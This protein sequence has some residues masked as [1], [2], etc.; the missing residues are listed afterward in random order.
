MFKCLNVFLFGSLKFE[1][2][3]IVNHLTILKY[4]MAGEQ[5]ATTMT[6]L[7]L[8]V[9]NEILSEYMQHMDVKTT[10]MFLAT[11]KKTHNLDIE[12]S[13][14]PSVA[15]KIEGLG[16]IISDYVDVVKSIHATLMSERVRDEMMANILRK[17]IYISVSNG[18]H[19]V[20]SDSL[21]A[22]DQ[23][24]AEYERLYLYF[25]EQMDISKPVFNNILEDAQFEFRGFSI[26]NISDVRRQE[27]DMFKNLLKGWYFQGEYT[28]QANI[29]YNDT[30][31]EIYADGENIVF[32][33]HR[34]DIDDDGLVFFQDFVEEWK[35][36]KDEDSLRD[37][38]EQ[39]KITIKNNRLEWPMTNTQAPKVIAE[40]LIKLMPDPMFYRGG[41]VFNTEVWNS[42]MEDNWLLN[43]V[44]NETMT[45]YRFDEA[46]SNASL[47]IVDDFVN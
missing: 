46:L 35:N 31:M 29:Q 38:F 5:V 18:T 2:P 25:V 22:F 8:D 6:N 21:I 42:I 34:H 26:I 7:L 11:C 12:G 39:S 9:P 4:L 27:L 30:C 32:D 17:L 33:V 45:S 40:L 10:I 1:M 13:P 16:N 47:Q 3:S 15:K 20:N 41:E 44:V 14:K 24:R 19:Y 23:C 37:A 43:E 28:A 36:K